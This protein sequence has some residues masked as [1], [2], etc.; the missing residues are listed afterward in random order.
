MAEETMVVQKGAPVASQV[1]AVAE[2]SPRYQNVAIG[3]KGS[4]R[5]TARIDMGA[6]HNDVNNIV[7]FDIDNSQAGAIT[8]VVRIG[9]W[10]GQPDAYAQFNTTKSGAD[11]VNGITDNFGANLL[12]C[13]GF[14]SITV[15]TPVFVK[16]IKVISAS[17]TQ[18]TQQ[19]SHKTVLPDF[20][21]IPLVQNIAF[22]REKQDQATDLLV[23]K[24]SWLLSSRDFLEFSSILATDVS[25]IFELASISDVRQFVKF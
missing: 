24:G 16:T 25:L 18:L 1:V 17:T 4:I 9:S 8:E 3:V 20:T 21:I 22:T 10:L 7:Q 19:F 12:K 2:V 13:Q 15:G 6:G 5:E 14:S 23:A 11:S